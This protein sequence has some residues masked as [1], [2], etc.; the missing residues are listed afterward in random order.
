VAS[1]PSSDSGSL[2]ADDALADDSLWDLWADAVIDCEIDGT[3]RW[4]RGPDAGPLPAV[5]PIFVLTAYNPNGLERDAALN[6]A[7]QAKL[8]HELTGR[9]LT[10]WPATG[11]SR[12]GSWSEPGFAVAGVDRAR[13]CELGSRYGQLAV[14]ELTEDEV[15][16][17]RCT[18]RE[19]VRTRAR[20]E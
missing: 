4:L 13:G 3:R 6:E 14:Y 20:V 2:T 7:D 18:N 19:I 15:H 9:S 5:A 17:V 8:E 11:R 12:D 16:V 1:P 10:F